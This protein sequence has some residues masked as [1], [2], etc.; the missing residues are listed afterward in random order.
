MIMKTP[1][2]P[3]PASRPTAADTLIAVAEAVLAYRNEKHVHEPG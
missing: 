3:E 1:T 2:K